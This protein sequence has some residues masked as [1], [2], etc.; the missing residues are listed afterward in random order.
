MSLNIGQRAILSSTNEFNSE[1]LEDINYCAH[2]GR[3]MNPTLSHRDL[4]EIEICNQV[5]IGDVIL[6]RYKGKLIV[7]RVVGITKEGNKTHGDN[8]DISDFE[9]ITQQDIIGRVVAAWKGHRRRKI[10][11]GLMG[12]FFILCVRIRRDLYR[13]II[14][15][16]TLI[17][18]LVVSLGV[19]QWFI[20]PFFYPKVVK[21]NIEGQNS[22][23]IM[24]GSCIIGHY[25]QDIDR[26]RIYPPFLLFINKN[27]LSQERYLI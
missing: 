20:S 8:N 3:S 18:Y 1:S 10:Y 19:L 15:T 12:R 26:W 6:F 4:L 13:R 11:G 2:T 21:F 22:L 5:F 23:R 17:Y 25:D 16:L 7:H 27:I 24:I 9:L 14:P